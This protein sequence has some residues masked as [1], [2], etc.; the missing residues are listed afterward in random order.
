MFLSYSISY[1]REVNNQQFFDFDENFYKLCRFKVFFIQFL[2]SIALL[3]KVHKLTDLLFN[4]C[5]TCGRFV[6]CK[7][8]CELYSERSNM[9]VS[10]SLEDC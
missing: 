7:L 2:H 6:D 4:S 8:C 1:S 10:H 3:F 9:Q 5:I